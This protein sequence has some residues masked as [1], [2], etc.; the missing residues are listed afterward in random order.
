VN[1]LEHEVITIFEGV[2]EGSDANI[3]FEHP[4][5]VRIDERFGM[6]IQGLPA[7]EHLV[8]EMI[9]LDY[10]GREWSYEKEF[11]SEDGNLE[12]SR[13]EM[14]RMI[15]MK[16]PVDEGILDLYNPP[17]EK[18][19]GEWNLT[20]SVRKDHDV[21]GTTNLTRTYGDPGVTSHSVE[22]DDII[23]E[24]FLSPGNLPA[25][26]VLVLH[27]SE[28]RKA[29]NQAHMLASNGFVALAIQYFGSVNG[30]PAEQIPV[31]LQEIPLEY[32]EKAGEWLL[33]HE[34]TEGSKVGIWGVS[35]GGELA[36]LAASHF[37][38]FGPTVSMVGSGVIWE[39]LP[40]GT[41]SWSY[42]NEPLPY[43]PVLHADYSYSFD[44]ASEETIENAIIPVEDIDGPIIAVCGEDDQFY[45]WNSVETIGRALDRLGEKGFEHEYEHLIYEDAGHFI[46]F[47]YL[48]TAN[49]HRFGGGGTPEGYAEANSDHWHIV[50]ETLEQIQDSNGDL[51]PDDDNGDE[52]S[53]GLGMLLCALPLV[54]IV[55][56]VLAVFM[57]KKK[58]G[59]DTDP[60]GAEDDLEE[61]DDDIF[62]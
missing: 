38:I 18:L 1:A 43:V 21:L 49:I 48:P 25:P 14:M 45:N 23:G 29:I 56:I 31:N 3:N 22:D 60:I 41:S 42:Q 12:L 40:L 61:E 37:E 51:P 2:E 34:Q 27:G 4:E 53:T 32:I 19:G 16:T 58:D 54:A 55:V 13:D 46:S 36:L 8:L 59:A 11:H 9:S 28:G 62:L 39:G 47:P 52:K 20:F 5:V 10:N 57:M 7:D 50:L 24:V 33:D 44:E 35:K 15:Q 6:N 17:V 30:R 26:G